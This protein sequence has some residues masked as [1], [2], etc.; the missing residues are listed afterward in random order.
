MLYLFFNAPKEFKSDIDKTFH[1][2]VISN[3]SYPHSLHSHLCRL[4][5]RSKEE[6]N[7]CLC[8]SLGVCDGIFL[9]KDLEATIKYQPTQNIFV[10]ND[11]IFVPTRFKNKFDFFALESGPFISEICNHLKLQ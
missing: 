2:F 11:F 4:N 8:S 1:W 5:P 7:R 3:E 6:F 10:G 9:I